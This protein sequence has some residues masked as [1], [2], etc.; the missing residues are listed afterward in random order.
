MT[1]LPEGRILLLGATGTMG[2]LTAREMVRQGLSPILT[3]PDEEQLN[4]LAEELG[5]Q[6]RTVDV[7][8]VDVEQGSGIRELVTSPEDIVVSALDDFAAS[9][10][11]VLRA[12]IDAGCGYLDCAWEP[13][14]IRKVFSSYST[15]AESKGSIVLS[16]FGCYYVAGSLAAT[17]AVRRTMTGSRPPARVDIGYFLTGGGRRGAPSEALIDDSYRWSESR[18]KTERPGARVRTFDIGAGRQAEALS[19]GSAEHFTVPR[20]AASI[21]DVN[22][23]VGWFGRMTRAAAMAGAVG[24]PATRLPG[25]SGMWD[26]MIRGI[27]SAGSG[28]P[29][30]ATG[31][32]RTVVVAS[33]YD[34]DGGIQERVLVEGPGPQ[35][36]TASLLAWGSGMVA[37]GVAHGA[38]A[39]GPT[40][41][42]GTEALIG[43]CMALGLAE[44]RYAY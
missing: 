13:A 11:P 10:S 6:A 5:S 27:G 20:L 43:G 38:G 44:Q 24:G 2:R 39:L 3:G 1:V 31:K 18:I 32:A 9:G 34:G 26:T 33:T 40:E 30:A 29:E 37:Q 14:F 21:T 36:L 19:L 16:G 23:Y 8:V 25:L 12:A 35:E 28:S 15:L 17:I 22:V 4:A 7:A 41:A 42:F